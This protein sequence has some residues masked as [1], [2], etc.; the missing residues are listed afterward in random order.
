MRGISYHCNSRPA[1]SSF[2]SAVADKPRAG[3][4]LL[5]AAGTRGCSLFGYRSAAAWSVRPVRSMHC[6]KQRKGRQ[7]S[8]TVSQLRSCASGTALQRATYVVSGCSGEAIDKAPRTRDRE[9][10]IDNLRDVPAWRNQQQQALVMVRPWPA[11]ALPGRLRIQQRTSFGVL[12]Q[13]VAL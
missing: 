2:W 1:L 6:F 10:L 8:V 11:R 4:I 13:R 9:H 5:P 7:A 3:R 12:G